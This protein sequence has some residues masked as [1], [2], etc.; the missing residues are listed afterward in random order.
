ML[1]SRGFKSAARWLLLMAVL[2]AGQW[3]V[4]AQSGKPRASDTGTLIKLDARER[5]WLAEHPRVV[6][7]SKQYPRY[8]FRDAEGRW[9][10]FNYDVLQRISAMTGLQF[11]YDESFSTGQLLA[12]LENGAADMSTILSMNDERKAPGLQSRLWRRSLGI[13]RPCA[14]ACGGV[15]GTTEKKGAGATQP[16]CPGAHHSP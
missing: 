3:A 2:G 10:G 16:T 13:R 6:V 8:L 15:A 1:V 14:G 9:S 12:R 4:A 7:A 11:V 5:Q